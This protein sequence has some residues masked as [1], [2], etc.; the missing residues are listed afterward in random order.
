MEDKDYIEIDILKLLK[1]LWHRAWAIVL[2]AVICGGMAFSYARFLITPLYQASTLIYVNN[3]SFSVGSTSF[4]ISASE[5]SA[6]QSLVDTYLVILKT[7]T[8]LNDVIEEAD[9]PYSYE[10]LYGM[11]SAAS[12]NSTEIFEIVVTSTDPREAEKIANTIGKV[13]PDR[14]SDVVDG[15]SVRIVDYAIVPSRK[16]SPNITKYTMVGIF[17][18]IVIS[19]GIV[20]LLELFDDVVHTED[21]ITQKYDL[22]LLA[23]IPDLLG[24]KTRSY[25]NY[26]RAKADEDI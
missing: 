19:C 13:L 25:G 14:I 9:L 5:L 18:G 2:S 21:D 1:A 16:S 24:T 10:Q 20:I 4:S 3:S 23:V 7:R 6:A 22:P 12:V 26:G 15:S 11:I 17:L 8:T